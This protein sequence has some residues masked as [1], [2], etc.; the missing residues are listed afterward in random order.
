MKQND[1]AEQKPRKQ[2]GAKALKD[3][4]HQHLADKNDVITEDDIRNIKIGDDAFEEDTAAKQELAEGLKQ[5]DELADAIAEKKTTSPWTIL[6]E[7]DK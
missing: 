2:K 1:G 4:V 6:S 7:E 3:R 5:G